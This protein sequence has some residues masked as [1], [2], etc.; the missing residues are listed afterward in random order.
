MPPETLIERLSRVL[1]ERNNAKNALDNCIRLNKGALGWGSDSALLALDLMQEEI[2]YIKQRL[3][4]AKQE[5][6]ERRNY[7]AVVRQAA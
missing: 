3:E 4:R 2:G 7:C 1:S 5:E 6:S